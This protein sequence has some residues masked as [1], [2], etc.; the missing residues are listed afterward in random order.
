MSGSKNSKGEG[1]KMETC[2]QFGGRKEAQVAAEQYTKVRAGKGGSRERQET[3]HTDASGHGKEL[4]SHSKCNGS[5]P[6]IF[7]AGP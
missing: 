1:P 4:G 3:A 5:Q 6:R 2:L 7:R